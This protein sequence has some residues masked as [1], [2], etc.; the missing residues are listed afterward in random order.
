M[1][2]DNDSK[3]IIEKEVL[4][5]AFY[6]LFYGLLFLMV[7][8]VLVLRDPFEMV[9][10]ISALFL[11]T[12]VYLIVVLVRDGELHSRYGGDEFD[13][14]RSILNGF[15][16]GSLTILVVYFT[17]ELDGD[18]IRQFIALLSGIIVFMVVWTSLDIVSYKISSRNN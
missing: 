10:D 5:K 12:S 3:E 11:I 14:K 4:S 1:S 15:L 18:P 9:W 6:I 16:V 13:I 8:R 7:L 2:S 17:T